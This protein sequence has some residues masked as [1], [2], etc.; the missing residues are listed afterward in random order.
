MHDRVLQA[1]PTVKGP[2]QCRMRVLHL[3]DP[4]PVAQGLAGFL[5]RHPL[6]R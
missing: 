2:K 5:T 1:T 3:L 6:S 4:E